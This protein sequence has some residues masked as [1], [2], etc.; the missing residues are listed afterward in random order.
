MNKKPTNQRWSRLI[1]AKLTLSLVVA[2]STLAGPVDPS[3]AQSDFT[4][5]N[6]FAPSHVTAERATSIEWQKD[7]ET[8]RKLAVDTDRL[9]LLHFEAPAWCRPCQNLDRFVFTNTQVINSFRQTV[10]PLRVDADTKDALVKKFGVTSV[11][12]DVV[13]TSRGRVISRRKSP[14]DSEGYG[15]MM[16][17]LSRTLGILNSADETKMA[18]YEQNL[19]E[20]EELL[21]IEQ[22]A[23]QAAREKIIPNKPEHMMPRPSVDSSNLKRRWDLSQSKSVGSSSVDAKPSAKAKVVSN[24]FF[25]KQPATTNKPSRDA[26]TPPGGQVNQSKH[27]SE[28]KSERAKTIPNRFFRKQPL[29]QSP[30]TSTNLP[31]ANEL[32]LATG[33]LSVDRQ[34]EDG[35]KAAESKQ[36]GDFEVE[37]P[38]IAIENKPLQNETSDFL[39]PLPP[40]FPIAASKKKLSHSPGKPTAKNEYAKQGNH[41]GGASEAIAAD[42]PV[43]AAKMA[44]T[45]SDSNSFDVN[46][47]EPVELVQRDRPE[48]PAVHPGRLQAGANPQGEAQTQEDNTAFDVG[49]REVAESL[50]V[51]EPED[52]LVFDQPAHPASLTGDQIPELE[53]FQFDESSDIANRQSTPSV[54]PTEANAATVNPSQP[55]AT[56]TQDGPASQLADS[57]NAFSPQPFAS[58]ADASTEK[59]PEPK[60]NTKPVGSTVWSAETIAEPDVVANDPVPGSTT[61][62]S[63]ST[64]SVPA[65]STA[66][67][68]EPEQVEPQPAAQL[69][70]TFKQPSKTEIVPAKPETKR[71]R[72]QTVHVQPTTPA[73]PREPAE[74]L[75][76]TLEAPRRTTMIGKLET[77]THHTA[78]GQLVPT[79]RPRQD[80]RQQAANSSKV[81]RSPVSSRPVQSSSSSL[82]SA[83]S[84]QSAAAPITNQARIVSTTPVP[85]ERIEAVGMVHVQGAKLIDG[86]LFLPGMT[87]NGSVARMRIDDAAASKVA[88]SVNKNSDP[89]QGP[90]VITPDAVEA[91]AVSQA[92]IQREVVSAVSRKSESTYALKGHCPVTLLTQGQWKQGDREIGVIHR[93]QVYLFVNEAARETFQRD[94]DLYSPLLAGF[95]PVI[96]HETGKLVKGDEAFGVFMGK[97]PNQRVVLFTSADTQ[98]QF[99][100]SPKQFIETVRQAMSK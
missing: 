43:E 21:R 39:P 48:R 52:S 35:A 98:S 54:P 33:E 50:K 2:A 25:N 40:K 66:A 29:S 47:F 89:V 19:N 78:V 31:K 13:L 14:R 37:L 57:A 68:V 88:S 96:Y 67:I 95:D 62:H 27:S 59:L 73:A 79:Q 61:V 45:P 34:Q 55:I 24:P 71:T 87:T 97:L 56:P 38:K 90:T 80:T 36:D 58:A 63:Q 23:F 1:P 64:A 5:S 82:R 83:E 17:T 10:V 94:P 44:E 4:P 41:Q 100:A 46:A 75:I 8:A 76:G 9:I 85:Q 18:M 12:F 16:K 30:N 99:K 84:A 7:F 22:T 72:S 15:S 3:I 74:T 53:E 20:L 70:R 69:A 60:L 28:V 26:V 77:L 81:Q 91:A 49:I 11:P 86:Q 32:K 93:R 6:S 42:P 51:G 65:G 92:S